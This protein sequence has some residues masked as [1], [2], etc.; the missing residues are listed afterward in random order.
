MSQNKQTL[1][2]FERALDKRDMETYVLRLYVSGA[3]PRSTEAIAKIKD[4]CEE[5]L[6][7]HYDLEVIDIYQRPQLAA[8]EQIIAAPTLV[9]ESPGGLRKM[10]GNL[11]NTRL[12]LQRLGIAN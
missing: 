9:K 2:E 6:P 5:Y 3:T 4:I 1:A 7:G 10:I 11:S 12:I 8:E